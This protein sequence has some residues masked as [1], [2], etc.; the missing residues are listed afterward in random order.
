MDGMT[1][2]L[3][4]KQREQVAQWIKEGLKLSEIQKLLDQEM[5]VRMTY[6]EVRF[7]M[8]DLKLQPV[9]PVVPVKTPEPKPAAPEVKP[10]APTTPAAEEAAPTPGQVALEMDAIPHPG[11]V[12]SGKVTFSDGMAATW[13]LDQSG[14][15]G[16]APSVKGYRPSQTDVQQFQA[17]LEEALTK[18]GI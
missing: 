10:A 7:L 18:S 12:V 15:L 1:M 8:D 13:Y 11:T 6:M 2:I 4:Q 14:R 9:D 17:A 16:M 5:G 3:D